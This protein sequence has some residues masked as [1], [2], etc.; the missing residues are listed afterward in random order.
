MRKL[1]LLFRSWM[2][3]LYK[4]LKESCITDI[5]ASEYMKIYAILAIDDFFKSQTIECEENY[6][7]R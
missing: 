5:Q 1:N 3:D 2:L 4:R 6:H 7:D